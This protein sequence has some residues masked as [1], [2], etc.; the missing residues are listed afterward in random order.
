MQP[1]P[2]LL[3]AAARRRIKRAVLDRV[4]EWN[5]TPQQFWML[6]AIQE[7]PGISQVEIA[8]R[9]RAEPPD[10]SRALAALSERGLV[11]S[12]TDPDDRRRTR[13]WLT[14]AGA[15]TT[16]DLAP[17]ARAIR[18]AVV[19]GMSRD[20]VDSLCAALQRVVANLD[21]LDA[22]DG[23]RAARERP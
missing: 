2:G 1:Y 10:V 5:L 23:R 17:I 3:I 14:R 20:E 7:T 13:I 6:V 16:K 8:A 18:G 9:T 15:R 4:A 12:E 22:T 19:A 21:A 11:R